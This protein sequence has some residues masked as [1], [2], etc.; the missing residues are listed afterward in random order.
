VAEAWFFG[1]TAQ[2]E[3]ALA[4]SRAASVN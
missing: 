1:D 2:T 4:P 3:R